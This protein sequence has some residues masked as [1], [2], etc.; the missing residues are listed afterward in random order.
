MSFLNPTYLWSLLGILIPIAIHLWNRKKVLT[1]KVGS[2]K[3]LTASEPKRTSSIRPNEWWLLV[4]RILMITLFGFILAGPIINKTKQKENLV[5]VVDPELLHLKSMEQLI[6]SLPS[7]AL[8]IMVSGFPLAE[9]YDVETNKFDV[10]NY[11]QMAQEM[12]HLETDSIIVFAKG[13]VSGIH[14]MRPATSVGI[15][16]IVLDTDEKT[17]ALLEAMVDKDSI[18]LLSMAS[19]RKSLSFTKSNIAKNSEKIRFNDTEDSIQ[20]NGNRIG[21]KPNPPLKILIVADD[22]LVNELKYLRAAYRAVGKF[23]DQPI[24][25]KRVTKIDTLDLEA[26][27]TLVWLSENKSKNHPITSLLYRPDSL[28]N[29]LIVPGDTRNTFFLTH[30]LN[31]ENTI[32]EHLPEKLLELLSLHDGLQEKVYSYDQ[33]TVDA[34]EL[35]TVKLSQKGNRKYAEHHDLSLWT[36]VLLSILLVVERILSKYRGQ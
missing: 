30:P 17:T 14:G 9:D 26:Y 22:G 36:W 5:Y 24:E 18:E 6:D 20:I 33:R 16:W 27:A 7:Q 4:L 28:A 29:E 21:V 11:W 8:R 19:D 35:Q 34:Q 25:M 2:I 32:K 12:Q 31:S 3:M 10:P 1:I 15:N 13:L 23:L